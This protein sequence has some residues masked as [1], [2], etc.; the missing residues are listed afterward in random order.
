[1]LVSVNT[2]VSYTNTHPKDPHARLQKVTPRDGVN[3]H[4]ALFVPIAKTAKLMPGISSHTPTLLL[5][6][7]PLGVKLLL[8]LQLLL[9]RRSLSLILLFCLPLSLCSLLCAFFLRADKLVLQLLQFAH[10]PASSLGVFALLI[11]LSTIKLDNS[12]LSGASRAIVD[13]IDVIAACV[14]STLPRRI[15]RRALRVML[16]SMF[17]SLRV[18]RRVHATECGGVRLLCAMSSH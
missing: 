17:V 4:N 3:E 18:V 2:F 12:G 5:S 1:M 8:P 10:E 13:C 6:R 11:G 16:F 9:K 7:I 14:A 15:R